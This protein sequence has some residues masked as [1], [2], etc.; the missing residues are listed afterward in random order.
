M[1]LMFIK[2]HTAQEIIGGIVDSDNAKTYLANI[3]ENFK[4]SSKNYASTIISKMLSS[5]YNGTMVHVS[6][7]LQGFSTVRKNVVRQQRVILD[8]LALQLMLK[9]VLMK[10]M[11]KVMSINRIMRHRMKKKHPEEDAQRHMNNDENQQ[12]RRSQQARKFAIP[13]YH[14]VYMNEDIGKVDG[15]TSFKEAISSKNSSKWFE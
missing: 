11:M 10:I 7:S 6:N 3:Q 12:L 4:S 14:E 1:A 9:K 8:P 5:T 2:S 13:D 15:P